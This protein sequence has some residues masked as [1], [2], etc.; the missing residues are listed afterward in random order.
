MRKKR[1]FFWILTVFTVTASLISGVSCSD[2]TN[3]VDLKTITVYK[4]PTCGCCTKWVNHLQDNG[5][6]VEAINRKDMN[7]IKSEAGIPRQLA[8]CHTA[9][10]DGYVIEGHVPAADITRQ[11][12][13]C[14]QRIPGTGPFLP[15]AWA[16]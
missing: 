1:F 11:S 7:G 8:S 14:I 16:C 12:R 10:I 5:F 9:I 3:P 13:S 6:K 15:L 2:S 4:S